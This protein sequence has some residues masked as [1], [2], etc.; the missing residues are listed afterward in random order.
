MA[1]LEQQQQKYRWMHRSHYTVVLWG[2]SL[3]VWLV[4]VVQMRSW[5]VGLLVA[6]VMAVRQLNTHWYQ[7]QDTAAVVVVAAVVVMPVVVVVVMPVAVV[8]AVVVEVVVAAA[9][10]VVAVVRTAVVRMATQTDVIGR[11]M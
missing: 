11:V 8:A 3:S 7:S 9:A 2:Q 1:P 5:T 6:V 10:A 4:A